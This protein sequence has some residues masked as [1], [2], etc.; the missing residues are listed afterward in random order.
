MRL[1]A[2]DQTGKKVTQPPRITSE[3][4]KVTIKI[5]CISPQ[6]LFSFL[7]IFPETSLHGYA[8]GLQLDCGLSADETTRI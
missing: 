5:P 4:Q 6:S 7:Y 3:L 8:A 2:T 1:R